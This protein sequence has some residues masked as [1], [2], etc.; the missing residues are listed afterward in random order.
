[1]RGARVCGPERGRRLAPRPL[2]AGRQSFNRGGGVPSWQRWVPLA[3]LPVG[4]GE[5]PLP[6]MDGMEEKKARSSPVLQQGWPS[7]MD[8]SGNRSPGKGT[9][10]LT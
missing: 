5:G 3:C 1:M 7:K 6:G 2:A 10:L 9:K 4:E 8:A